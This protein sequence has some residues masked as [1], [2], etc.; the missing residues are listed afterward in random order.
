MDGRRGPRGVGALAL[1]VSAIAHVI[2]FVL[3][4]RHVDAGL[5][6]ALERPIQVTLVP[7]SEPISSRSKVRTTSR[8]PDKD[9]TIPSPALVASQPSPAAS[10]G[11]GAPTTAAPAEARRPVLQGLRAG[12]DSIRMTREEREDCEARRWAGLAPA[13]PRLNLDPTGRY[14]RNPEPFLSRRPEK[15]CRARMT[16][17]T[18]GMGNDMNARVGITCVKRF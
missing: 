13:A 11:G 5:P 12:C 17:D 10:T 16:G 18:D 1:L 6:E 3:L 14:A 9:A 15:G 2:L 4:A 7:P 8:R